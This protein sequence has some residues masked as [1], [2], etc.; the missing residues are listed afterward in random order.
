MQRDTRGGTRFTQHLGPFGGW[1]SVSDAGWGGVLALAL[2]SSAMWVL[3]VVS[4]SVWASLL[5]VLALAFLLIASSTSLTM[6]LLHGEMVRREHYLGVSS[7]LLEK[8]CDI[9]VHQHWGIE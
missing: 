7:S 6:L 4:A 2:R 1:G 3:A 9:L 8:A 5:L